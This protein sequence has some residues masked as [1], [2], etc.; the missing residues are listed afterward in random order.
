MRVIMLLLAGLWLALAAPAAAQDGPGDARRLALAE[1]YLD[2]TQG[3]NLRKTFAAYFEESFAKLAVPTEQR[4]WLTQN[5]TAA[6]NQAMQATF[7]DVADDVADLFSEAE[8][9]AM[10]AFSETPIGRSIT[11]KSFELG[12]TLQTVMAPHL[13]S[14]MTQV[15]EKY[16][17]RFDCEAGDDASA[18]FG[19]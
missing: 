2:L 10:I 5:V 4:D 3:E 9:E 1:R 15:G 6:F 7:A 13:T 16:C 14:A 11:A 17:A 12:V 8:L 19:P 18:K